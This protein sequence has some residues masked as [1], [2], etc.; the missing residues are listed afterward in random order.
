MVQ[1]EIALYDL[2]PPGKLSTAFYYFGVGIYHTSVRIPELQ[3]EFA[4]GGILP[5]SQG[6]RDVSNLT[7][8]FVLPSPDDP[9]VTER[10]MPGLRFLQRIDVGEA[11]GAAWERNVNSRQKSRRPHSES[12]CIRSLHAGSF[13]TERACRSSQTFAAFARC[14]L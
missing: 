7:G 5:G 13:G 8:I 4:Y 9:R 1:V 3:V 11:F 14:H 6:N 12:F 10:L 2:L